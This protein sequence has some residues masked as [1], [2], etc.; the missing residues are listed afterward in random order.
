MVDQQDEMPTGKFWD[1]MVPNSSTVGSHSNLEMLV[2][3]TMARSYLLLIASFGDHPYVA[4][5][6]AFSTRRAAVLV[7]RHAVPG[8]EY[9][10][11]VYFLRF[12]ARSME[13][14]YKRDLEPLKASHVREGSR[15]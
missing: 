8:F 14:E 10:F 2:G 13:D 4:K 7:S 15:I 3:L 11:E 9:V 6:L 5:Y 1:S 12:V